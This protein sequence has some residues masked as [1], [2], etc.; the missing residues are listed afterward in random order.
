MIFDRTLRNI[1]RIQ[2]VIS[3]LIKYGFEEIVS[4]TA[5]KRFVPNK[6]KIRWIRQNRS[7]FEYNRWE[8]IRMA[9]EELGPTFVKGAQVLSN[10]ADIL[11]PELI[12]EFE[13]LLDQVPAVDADVI[14]KSLRN[15]EWK[16]YRGG[17]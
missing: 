14:K 2:Q 13:K 1:K 11:P 4:T 6:R 15:R 7:I 9:I 17:V 10:R 3:V 8:R 12:H 16:E 5:L